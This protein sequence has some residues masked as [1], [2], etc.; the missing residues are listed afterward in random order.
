MTQWGKD[1]NA[2]E[3]R[4]EEAVPVAKF[5]FKNGFGFIIPDDITSQQYYQQVVNE[6]KTEDGK[7]YRAWSTKEID[8]LD[9]IVHIELRSPVHDGFLIQEEVQRQ[10]WDRAWPTMKRGNIL[11][12]IQ[13][14]AFAPIKH[15]LKTG[16]KGEYFFIVL[17][18][19]EEAWDQLAQKPYIGILCL[20]FK[21]YYEKRPIKLEEPFP[22]YDD[23]KAAA[24]KRA[25]AREQRENGVEGGEGQSADDDEELTTTSSYVIRI[26]ST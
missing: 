9:P 20:Q 11:A 26:L 22:S 8:E 19:N 4:G 15:G 5:G 1:A 17:R 24:D 10:G 16:P 25:E 13:P 12:K 7:E 23:R 14:T 3:E 18:I 6:I 21:V 2:A